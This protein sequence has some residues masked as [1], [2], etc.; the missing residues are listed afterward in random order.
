VYTE[1]NGQKH[2]VKIASLIKVYVKCVEHNSRPKPKRTG[3]EQAQRTCMPF[4]LGHQSPTRILLLCEGVD[5]DPAEEI[6]TYNQMLDLIARDKDNE[7]TWKFMQNILSHQG[8]GETSSD[9]LSVIASDD[10]V[11]CVVYAKGKNKREKKVVRMVS[12]A[13]LCSYKTTP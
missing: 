13:K 6:I 9:S 7:I 4:N 2:G 5:S 3:K 12:H 11:T 8:S 1:E 10:A